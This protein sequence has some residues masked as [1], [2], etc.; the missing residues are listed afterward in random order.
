MHTHNLICKCIH[1]S[2]S[3]S[4]SIY[5]YIYICVCVCVCVCVC[6]P[7]SVHKRKCLRVCSLVKHI[8][9]LSLSSPVSLSLFSFLF[10]FFFLSFF[11]LHVLGLPNASSGILRILFEQTVR[12]KWIEPITFR[13]IWVILDFI[14][15]LIPSRAFWLS[16]LMIDDPGSLSVLTPLNWPLEMFIPDID[17][18]IRFGS[19]GG[20]K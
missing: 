4:L 16:A 1:F 3:L 15:W 6:M 7:A 18:F 5:I 9:P 19:V 17:S 20:R 8:F 10:Y 13:F 14:L 11:C 2:F 12:S